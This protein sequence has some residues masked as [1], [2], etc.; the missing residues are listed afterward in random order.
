MTLIS[1]ITEVVATYRAVPLIFLITFTLP[2]HCHSQ[3]YMCGACSVFIH[4]S[5]CVRKGVYT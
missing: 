2:L 1:D 3:K 5:S 4:I